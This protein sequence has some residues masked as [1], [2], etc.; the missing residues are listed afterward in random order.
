MRRFIAILIGVLVLGSVP[1]LAHSP[2]CTIPGTR[3]R[4]ILIGTGGSDVIC[5]GGGNDYANGR[6]GDDR[7]R[8][9]RGADLVIGGEGQDRIQGRKGNDRVVGVDGQ[10]LDQ[11]FGGPG[12]D[13]C[14]VDTGDGFIGCEHIDLARPQVHERLMMVAFSPALVTWIRQH[15]QSGG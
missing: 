6:G 5:A 14:H 4:D 7:V 13:T 3:Q 1:A 8:G 15:E 2:A 9:G 12:D 10:P 11:L